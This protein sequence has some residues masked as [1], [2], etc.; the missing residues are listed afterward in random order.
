MG[1]EPH[2]RAGDLHQHSSCGVFECIINCH[3]SFFAACSN[4]TVTLEVVC[5]TLRTLASVA[6]KRMVY[7]EPLLSLWAVSTGYL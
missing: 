4:T 6:G 7:S 2:Q 5:A 3:F 1:R